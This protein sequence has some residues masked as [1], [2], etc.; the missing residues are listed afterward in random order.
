MTLFAIRPLSL[1]AE[2]DEEEEVVDQLKEGWQF[3]RQAI[4]LWRLVDEPRAE[5]VEAMMD[6]AA[7]ADP[8]GEPRFEPPDIGEIVKLLTGIAEALVAAG[9]VDLD[10]CV[11]PEQAEE[12]GRRVPGMD[13]RSDRSSP[14]LEQALA[15][16]MINAISIRNFF[17]DAAQQ[18]C[19]VV[20]A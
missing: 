4:A 1:D 14:E 18:G 12:L 17:A 7:L 3:L 10:W 2:P 9:V 11:T 15:E 8:E 6:R 19:A 5:K 13:L 20:L 16:V